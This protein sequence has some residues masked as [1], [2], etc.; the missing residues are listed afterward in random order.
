VRS[1][2][3]WTHWWTRSRR[4]VGRDPT[5][6]AQGARGDGR[7]AVLLDEVS[8]KVRGG[9]PHDEPDD[10]DLPHWAGV[11]PLTTVPGAPAPAPDLTAGV[12]VPE[13]VAGWA[14]P[15]RPVAPPR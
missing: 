13:H 12:A 7:P 1:G 3:R 2:S 14:R 10:L 9:P 8:V 11:L 15:V 5:A 6:D 4:Q